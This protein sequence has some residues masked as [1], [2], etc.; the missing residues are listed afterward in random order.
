MSIMGFSDTPDTMVPPTVMCD[1]P[2]SNIFQYDPNL[3]SI[4][5]VIMPIIFGWIVGGMIARSIGG[6]RCV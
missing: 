5:D 2:L 1:V 3:K 6:L 4:K